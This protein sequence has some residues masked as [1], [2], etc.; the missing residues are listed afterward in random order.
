LTKLILAES[1]PQIVGL[2]AVLGNAKELAD[3]MRATLCESRKRPVELRRGVLLNGNF[4]YIEQNSGGEGG[5]QLASV[6]EAG[7]H[8]FTHYVAALVEKGE[9]CLVFC[10][11]RKETIEMARAISCAIRCEE[12]A[13]AL[14]EIEDIEDSEGKGILMNL[15]QC[16]IAYHNSDLDWEQ[17]QSQHV[18]VWCWGRL[19]PTRSPTRS[20]Q[21]RSCLICWT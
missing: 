7:Q 15:L 5:E 13:K 12:S 3:W 2:S 19:K 6:P 1:K 17:R 14:A 10:K 11:S 8:L 4:H 9:Q 18:T 16:G 21:F 20:R